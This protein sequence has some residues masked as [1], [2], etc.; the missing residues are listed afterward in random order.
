MR[1]KM[2]IIGIYSGLF[3][4]GCI[5]GMIVGLIIAI[6]SGRDKNEVKM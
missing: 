1:S 2:K 3:G 4:A 6:R 5:I